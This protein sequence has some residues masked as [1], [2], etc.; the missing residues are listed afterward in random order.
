MN[1]IG[2][3]WGRTSLLLKTPFVEIHLIVIVPNARSSLHL[4]NF[5][6]NWFYVCSGNVVIETHKNNYDLVDRTFLS[7]G[8]HT[9]VLPGEYHRFMTGADGAEVLEVYYP[10]A[11]SEDIVRKDCGGSLE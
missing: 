2:K 4:H 7:K 1:I 5:K 9:N 8:D 3:V 11:L 10:E 6:N